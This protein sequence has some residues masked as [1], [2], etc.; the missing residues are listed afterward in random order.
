MT[1]I[2]DIRKNTKRTNGTRKLSQVKYIARHHSATTDGDF[3]SFWKTWNGVKGWGTGGY[4]EIILRDGSVQLCYDPE[5]IT[6][7]VANHNTSTYHICV[8]GNSSFTAKQE[9]VFKERCLYNMKR[10][11]VPVERVLGHREFKG[12]ATTCPGINMDTVRQSL[13]NGTPVQQDV[14]PASRD[15]LFYGD[16]N[17]DV[18]AMIKYL[19]KLGYKVDTVNLYNST[20]KK[21]VMQFQDD[22][23][24]EDDGVYGK[25]TKAEMNKALKEF[26][27]N[28]VEEVKPVA[29]EDYEKDASAG[30]SLIDGQEWVKEHK[31]SDGSYPE[32]PVTRAELWQTLLNYHN[33]FNA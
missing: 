32:R 7:G 11:N 15:Y 14:K 5:E 17:E 13:K 28:P 1:V 31:I 24:L 20:A 9:E 22:R 23:G 4:H 6:N 18:A 29:D 12:A 25:E 21:A 16:R 26:A 19:A 8:V 2:H 3:N 27:A 30:K 33:K 10:L